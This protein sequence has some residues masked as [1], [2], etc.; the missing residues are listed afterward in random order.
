MPFSYA[1]P[2]SGPGAGGIGWFVFDMFTAINPGQTIPGLT[3]TLND[4]TIVK[5]D[6]TASNVSGTSLSF[7]ASSVPVTGGAAFGTAGYTG[8]TGNAALY[9]DNLFALGANLLTLSNISV[10]D[11]LGNPVPNYSVVVADAETTGAFESWIWQTNGGSW[12]Q[13]AQ[14]GAGTSPV[15]TGLGTT[16]ATLTGDNSSSANTSF[17][18]TTLNPT[19]LQLTTVNSTTSASGREAVSI[20]FAITR[21]DLQK[22]IGRRIDSSD[23]FDLII[24]G[25]P[26]A[27]ITTTGIANGIQPM[28]AQVYAI[29]GGSYSLNE[30][31]A[32]GSVS[33]SG[34]YALTVSA[35]NA[36]PA[37]SV[38]PVGALPIVF[39]PKLG[40]YVTYTFLNAAP[41]TFVK[42]VDKAYADIYEVLTYTVTVENINDFAV[43]NV[44]VTDATPVGTTYIGN[45]SVSAPYTGINPADCITITTIN[46]NSSVTLS[47]QI[48]INAVPPVP[49]PIPNYADVSVPGGISGIT[50]VVT[51]QVNTAYVTVSKLVDK[52]YAK[53]GEVLTYTLLLNN[54]G[55]VSA[56][57]VTIVDF[58]PDGTTLLPGSLTGATGIFPNLALTNPIS[59]GGSATI[60]F[61]VKIDGVPAVN[62]IPNNASVTYRYTV[63]PAQP[64]SKTR[65]TRSNTVTTL[66]TVAALTVTKAVD[67]HTA[68][69]GD[70]ITYQLAVK[71]T[72][73][74]T[75]NNVVLTDLLPIGI[76]FVTGSLIVSVP[77]SGTPITEIQFTNPVA[78]GQMLTLS[79]Q[80]KVLAMPNP[81]P[82]INQ[83]IVNYNYSVDPQKPNGET[84]IITSNSVCTLVFRYNYGQQINDLIESVALEQAA[85][86]AIA[87]AEG[88]KIQKLAAMSDI[89]TQELLCLN[90]SVS[91][92]MESITLLE[93]IL[94][95]KL[96]IVSCQINGCNM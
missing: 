76:S 35:S 9:A 28:L 86:A 27:Q 70:L 72:G 32:P 40:D 51:T 43:N 13:L 59:A 91:D 3:G 30:A 68:Y 89:T 55:N 2:T 73:N 65:T 8:I 42:A 45:L 10:Q 75:A 61:Q 88:A 36:T 6:L 77:Y 71:N 11:N 34:D 92:M 46:A 19:L 95:Q 14:L 22:N 57:D 26:A 85:L 58:I 21:V 82:V 23:Q 5:F 1:N 83:A 63:N 87:N 48:Q 74:V 49:N 31:M 54:S 56:E 33:A 24:N 37:G 60:T 39:A 69:L 15:L 25:S 20:G 52:A 18:L 81:N 62:P 29:P 90:K 53:P 94:K 93:A 96:S 79:F 80:V 38:P 78:P 7:E 17:V 47:W 16:T 44:L 12:A 50:N 64:G 41:Q 67:K 84:G 4:G 66:V